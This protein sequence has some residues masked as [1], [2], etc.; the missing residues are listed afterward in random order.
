MK[1]SLKNI[2]L[3][4]FLGFLFSCASFKPY[5]APNM[6]E[7]IATHRQIAILP[8]DVSFNDAYMKNAY[9][10]GGREQS[11]NHWVEQQRLAGLDMQKELYLQIAKQVSKGKYRE[12]AVKDFMATNKILQENNIPMLSIKAMNK[13]ELARILGVDAVV[14]G[15]TEIIVTNFMYGFTPSNSG[16]E[17]E[18]MLFDAT[19]GN[20]LWSDKTRITPSTRMDT[21]HSLSNQTLSNVSRRLPY[22]VK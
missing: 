1:I 14:W 19:S 4:S 21:P 17:T 15:K 8:F 18:A 10:R 13:G 9:R 3:I 22:R 16:V 20:L 11:E 6:Q 5:E 2:L 12:V 7:A